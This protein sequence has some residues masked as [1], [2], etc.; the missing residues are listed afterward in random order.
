MEDAEAAF[1]R[2]HDGIIYAFPVVD[3]FIFVDTGDEEEGAV[4]GACLCDA[5]LL[6][7]FTVPACRRRSN[8]L[9]LGDVPE[10]LNVTRRK[11]IPAAVNVYDLLAMLDT[12]AL[13]ELV[14]CALF[15]LYGA[16]L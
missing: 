13:D 8:F 4:V 15:F 7:F 16:Q 10:K 3:D 5:V 9:R 14:E 1:K 11:E 12:F 2:V 6:C